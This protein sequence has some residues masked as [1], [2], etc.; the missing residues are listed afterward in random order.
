MTTA[1]TIILL[2]LSIMMIIEYF[3]TALSKSENKKLIFIVMWL[4]SSAITMSLLILTTIDNEKL[5]KERGKCPEYEKIENV[6]RL[7]Q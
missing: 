6:Y 4:F 1:Q 3:G 7:K 5:L 2:I